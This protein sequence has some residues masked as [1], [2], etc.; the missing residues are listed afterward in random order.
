M[1]KNKLGKKKLVGRNEAERT[2]E[3]HT[4]FRPD[5]VLAT[6]RSKVTS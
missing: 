1:L 4:T 5:G 3:R 6:L 2:V